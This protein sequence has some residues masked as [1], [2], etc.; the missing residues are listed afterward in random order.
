MVVIVTAVTYVILWPVLIAG[1]MAVIVLWVFMLF[2]KQTAK[3]P[4]SNFSGTKALPFNLQ[5]YVLRPT[6]L[7][8]TINIGIC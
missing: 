7:Q 1:Q 4:I 5:L 2:S 6:T 8:D 3:C